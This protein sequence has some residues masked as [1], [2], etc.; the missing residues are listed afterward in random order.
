MARIKQQSHRVTETRRLS[1]VKALK[2]KGTSP[3]MCEARTSMQSICLNAHRSGTGKAAAVAAVG[4]GILAAKEAS[5]G[6]AVESVPEKEVE[7]KA[8]IPMSPEVNMALAIAAIASAAATA[9]FGVRAYKTRR[10]V[11]GIVGP[12]GLV[13][14]DSR[15]LDFKKNPNPFPELVSDEEFERIRKETRIFFVKN[16]KERYYL[17]MDAESMDVRLVPRDFK[18]TFNKNTLAF[19]ASLVAA[20]AFTALHLAG[21]E[22][23]VQT[24]EPAK[25]EQKA[26]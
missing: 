26:D 14:S 6:K 25:V 15:V 2:A 24:A 7:M 16:R 5:A 8:E 22:V 13:P 18:Y 19:M 4:V 23:P 21:K 20:L 9:I 1:Q 3:A 11:P 17:H 10:K 12:S